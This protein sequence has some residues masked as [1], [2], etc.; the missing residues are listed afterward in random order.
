MHRGLSTFR[1]FLFVAASLCSVGSGAQAQSSADLQFSDFGGNQAASLELSGEAR[2]EGS[3]LRLTDSK[4]RVFAGAFVKDVVAF[5]DE[6]SFSAYFSFKMSNPTCHIGLGGDGLAFVIQPGLV[7]AEAT[8]S[9]MGFDKISSSLAIEFDTFMNTTIGD[10]NNN[11]VGINLKGTTQS[12][13]AEL[14][15]FILNDGSIYHAWVDYNGKEQFLEVRLSQ[16]D[17]RP[18]A[19][20]VSHT[21][22]LAPILDSRSFVGFTAGTGDCW[23]QHDIL[24]FYFS[25]S[26]VAGGIRLGS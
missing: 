11:H 8:G 9:G 26:F 2:I 17:T 13:A 15:P 25:K 1:A 21:V 22:D 4:K 6:R 3:E 12:S 10:R 19:A 23:Q 14:A 20:L 18:E 7:T 5:D 16:S 24:S